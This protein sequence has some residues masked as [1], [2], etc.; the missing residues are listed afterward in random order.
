MDWTKLF[1]N[2][3]RILI[4]G[5]SHYYWKDC[6]NEEKNRQESLFYTRMLFTTVYPFANTQ[7][8]LAN[9]LVNN[10]YIAKNY[11]L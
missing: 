2:I 1:I 10:E 3:L 11:I 8:L 9:D 5:K 4:L 7:I 6:T